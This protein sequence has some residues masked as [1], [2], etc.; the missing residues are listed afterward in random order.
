MNNLN[1]RLEA[2]T[3][4]ALSL[5]RMV[6]GFLFTAFGTSKLFDWPITMGI[7]TGNWPAWYAGIIEFVGGLLIMTGLFTRAAAFISAGAMAVAY[8]WQHQPLG[9]WPIVPPEYGGN[10]GLPAIAFCFVFFL[11]IFTGGGAHS[12]DTLRRR[13]PQSQK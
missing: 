3:P 2:L 10:G 5:V 4:T 13:E 9:V 1:A 11:L 12:L 6:F 8:F 7:P